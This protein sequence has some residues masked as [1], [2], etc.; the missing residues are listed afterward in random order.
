MFFEYL[1]SVITVNDEDFIFFRESSEIRECHRIRSVN[2]TWIWDTILAITF[3]HCIVLVF[4]SLTDFKFRSR[5]CRNSTNFIFSDEFLFST[6]CRGND[7]VMA[8]YMIKCIPYWS[9]RLRWVSILKSYAPLWDRIW[10]KMPGGRS[11]IFRIGCGGCRAILCTSH[12]WNT[13]MF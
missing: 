1:C 12:S 8:R 5:S 4:D 3:D 6:N 10:Y 9:V 11:N 2:C 7:L 13:I